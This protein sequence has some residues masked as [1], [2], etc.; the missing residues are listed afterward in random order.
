MTSFDKP[1][2]MPGD[3]RV[4]DRERE[5]VAARLRSA[6]T[7]GLLTLAESDERQ[8]AA[9][10]AT[11]RSE[12]APLTAD[13]PVP[14]PSRERPPL[15]VEARRRL[16]VHAGVVAVLVAFLVTRFAFDPAPFFWPVFPAFWLALSVVVHHRL[17]AR[18]PRE[19]GV[20]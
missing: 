3:V 12:L 6:A 20:A 10:A 9:Y 17:A 14:P 2:P 5:A 13:L 1:A 4:S 18:Q 15:T 11:V 19:V 16:A 8:Q 7:D